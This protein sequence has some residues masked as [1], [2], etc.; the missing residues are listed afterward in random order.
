ME[1][2][3]TTELGEAFVAD[4]AGV[5]DA[6]QRLRKQ[7]IDV[8]NLKTSEAMLVETQQQEG[9]EVVV[10]KPPKPEVV[11]VPTYDPQAVYAP[12]PATVATTTTTTPVEDKTK[13]STG[14][15]VTTGLL[16]FGAGILVNEIFDD[17]DDDY[18]GSYY[19][20]NYGYGGMPYYPP[21]PYR[22]TYGGGYYPSNGYNRPPNY[23][24]GFQNN[25]NI[26]I[27]NPG[28]GG[29]YW[30][31]Y[32]SGSGQ[33]GNGNNYKQPRQVSSPITAARPNR[34]ELNDLNKRQPRPIPA[35][36]KRPDKSA[37]AANW[38]GQ[39][40]YAGK[41]KRPANAARTPQDRIAEAQPGYSRPAS[42]NKGGAKVP[43]K[44][45][46]SYAGKD[47]M[48]RPAPAAK[49][50]TRD[51]QRPQTRDVQ[52]PAQRPQTRDVQKPAQRPTP[53]TM[54][55]GDRGYGTRDMQRPSPKPSAKPAQMNRP[56]PAARPAPKKPTAMSGANRGGKADKAA[57]Q[58][59]K[60]SMPQGARSKG[61]GA[62]N[63]QGR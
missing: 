47:R 24:N 38:K 1:M 11:Y 16:A 23:N 48:Q 37:T 49:P 45:Q 2:A 5:L 8:G 56:S 30:D 57:S 59:G 31:R 42:A 44:V 33:L 54:P 55:T 29:G 19:Y 60:Q 9:Q 32:P 22:P 3:W 14:N 28:G 40:S 26:I 13:Y 34:P 17:D 43:P 4:Q 63:K 12:P 58:R 53:K 18:R 50:A 35:D 61:S 25:G 36:Y 10:L 39:S 7:A 51:V 20:P 15:M 27:N 62:K 6:V 46:G 21:Y 52:K 41:D